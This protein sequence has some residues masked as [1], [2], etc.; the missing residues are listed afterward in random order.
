MGI[1]VSGG[2]PGCTGPMR[3]RP[4]H[5]VVLVLDDVAVPDELAGLVELGADAG[6]LAGI[7]DDRVLEAGLPG[8]G[9]S[10]G[11]RELR[12]ASGPIMPSSK[13][14]AWRLTTSKTTSW[15]C[16]GWASAVKL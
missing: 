2:W 16:I 4:H 15:T 5:L 12:R 11:A 9:R 6:D 14:I 7:G 13:L 3:I 10:G 1:G 8:F